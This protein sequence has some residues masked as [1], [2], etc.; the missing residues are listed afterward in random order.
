M[1]S[2]RDHLNV[3]DRPLGN[4]T[5]APTGKTDGR[6]QSPALNIPDSIAKDLESPDARVRLRALNHWGAPETQAS[7]DPVFEAL[8]DE[9]EAVRAKAAAIVEQYWAIEQERDRG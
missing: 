8:E 9:D 4:P 3:G 2:Q 7:L 1:I 5:V 6:D